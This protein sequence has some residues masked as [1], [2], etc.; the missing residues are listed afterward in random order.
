[1][2]APHMTT[3][4][5]KQANLR[6]MKTI[7]TGLFASMAVLYVASRSLE[8][9]VHALSY[10][11]TFTEAAMVGALAD[12]F[13]VVALFRHPLGIPLPHTAIIPQNKNQIG[14]GLANFV[15]KYFLTPEIVR[16]K[17]EELELTARAA[18]WLKANSPRVAE[19]ITGFLPNLLKG[20]NDEDIHRFIHD[21]LTAR[22]KKLDSALLLGNLLEVVTS[23]NKHL[24]LVDEILGLL[25]ELVRTNKAGIKNMIRE[26]VPLPDWALIK[27]IKSL[28]TNFI[29]DRAVHKIETLLE[30]VKRDPRH[31]LRKT[32]ENKLSEF[33]CDLRSSPALKNRCEELKEKLLTDPVLGHYAGE[34]WSDIKKMILADVASSNSKIRLHI[35][36]F[37]SELATNLL[38]DRAVRGKLD[39]WLRDGLLDLVDIYKDEVKK[40]IERTVQGWKTQ[41]VTR[42]F[43]LEIGRDL[44]FIRLNGTIIGGLVGLSLHVISRLIWN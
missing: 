15:V 2:G 37:T 40:T 38:E 33:I 1:M 28:I 13:A 4:D 6:R 34:V 44:Q 29:A 9:S 35:S 22:L 39:A 30:D 11:T 20:I 41:E 7:A 14:A 24:S 17:L 12:W 43:E 27:T 5:D 10:L 3:T 31:P 8:P 23:G 16:A 32:F 42:K 26:E 25:R 18:G 21:Q 36:N 19:I